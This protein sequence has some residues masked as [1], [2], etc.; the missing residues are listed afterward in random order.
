MSYQ[1]TKEHCNLDL[2]LLDSGCNNHMTGN[3][4]LFSSLDSS[5][6]TNIKLGDDSLVPAKGK[7]IIPV[8]SNQNEKMSIHEVFYVPHLTVNLISIGQLLQN[9]YDVRF[10]DTYCAIY[11]KPP[12]KRLIANVEMT[13]NRIF[14]LIIRSANLP[15]PVVHTVSSQD[16]SWL[17]HYRFGDIP[18]KSLHLL[19]KQSMVKGLPV[20]HKQSS[21]CEDCITGKHHKDSFPTSTS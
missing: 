1:A 2:W 4:S 16:Q 12:S 19:H 9:K 21:T 10:H 20:I 15:H 8:L 3:K 5:V 13:K 18:F 6:V 14:P 7:G 11:D 17:W